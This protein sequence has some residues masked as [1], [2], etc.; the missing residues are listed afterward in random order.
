MKDNHQVIGKNTSRK[1]P[2]VAT[3]ID[4]QNVLTIQNNPKLLIDFAKL[5]GRLHCQKAYFNSHHPNEVSATNKLKNVGCQ[6]V[7]ILY[8]YKNSLDQRL[9][10]DCVNLVAVKPSPDIIILVLGDRDFAG[11]ISLL[12]AA[13]KRV[14]IVAQRGSASQKLVKLVGEENFHYV[15]E[16]PSLVAAHTESKIN[17]VP[18]LITYNEAVKYLIE[19]IKT[20][21]SKGKRT[22]FASIDSIMRQLFPHYKGANSICK[23]D[24]KTFSR[25]KKFVEAA[26]KDG[27]VRIENQQLFLN[28]TA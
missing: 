3:F 28:Q 19:A 17:S 8:S 15:D 13:H 23:H 10:F 12:L 2:L 11:L 5:Q 7:D 27:V 14:I 26:V 21:S 16:L 18:C 25:F 24:G 22:V 1:Q 9:I 20:A 4:I 6:A